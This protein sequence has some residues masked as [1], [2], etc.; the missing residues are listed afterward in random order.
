L[1]HFVI[2][3]NVPDSTWAKLSWP[4]LKTLELKDLYLPSDGFT[5]FIMRHTM[6]L[7]SVALQEI[8]LHEG[9]SVDPLQQVFEMSQLS[10]RPLCSLYQKDS[11][12]K[13]PDS[14]KLNFPAREREV[15]LVDRN[16]SDIAAKILDHHFWTTTSIGTGNGRYVVDLRL[17]KAFVHGEIGYEHRY[18]KLFEPV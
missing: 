7:S 14:F 6:T 10:R 17:V 18:W 9:T 1:Q 4:I 2:E 5:A 11:S 15:Q 8:T 12:A 3:G 13:A 16:D